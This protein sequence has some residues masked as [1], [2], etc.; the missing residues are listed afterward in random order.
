MFEAQSS[1]NNF[2]EHM[3]YEISSRSE[4]DDG[5]ALPSIKYVTDIL[6]VF[7][8]TY[9]GIS[10]SVYEG[11]SGS[12]YGVSEGVYKYVSGSVYEGVIG[13]IY[14]DMSG[15]I[16]KGVN[17]SI[18]EDINRS[19]Y[20]GVSESVEDNIFDDFENEPITK[21]VKNNISE[22]GNSEDEFKNSP[23]REIHIGQT[24][25]SF[26]VLEQC[27]KHYLT[28]MRFKTKIV[29]PMKNQEWKS[30]YIDCEFLLN[31]S[32]QKCP[33]LVFVNK[34]NEKHTHNLSKSESLQQF[35][36]SFQKILEQT[37]LA[38]GNLQPKVQEY[39]DHVLYLTKECWAYVFT[40]R[41]FS[42]NTHSTQCIENEAKYT[43]L[44][45]FWN[46]NPTASLLNVSNMI[47]KNIDD[48]YKKY[49]TQNSLVLQQKQILE[50]D[51]YEKLQILLNMA[52]E[53]CTES[54]LI[55][56]R[57]YSGEGL[58][59]FDTSQELSIQVIKDNNRPLQTETFQ[60]LEKIRGQEINNR[61]AIK[62]D[63][64]KATYSRGLELC[65]KALDMAMMS[66]SNGVLKEFMISNPIQ[67][68]DKGHP[69]S[70]RYLLAIEN[71]G[72][73]NACSNNQNETVSGS[74]KKNKHQCALCRS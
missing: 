16:Y 56:F 65:K 24:F 44:Q 20:K 61:D 60:V 8:N 66:S 41:K 9:E 1:Y 18:Y 68:K 30:A 32:Y 64:K 6:P 22:G 27:L 53:N 52:L 67:Y 63:S 3:N 48:M 42:A 49:L 23:L 50:K 72:T 46:M 70:K 36:P 11:A 74:M 7:E 12:I 37:K 25:T 43:K 33:N 39:C 17:E 5:F 29:D 10:G 58:L 31:V 26:E 21:S 13:S 45:E 51:D 59:I 71:H 19:I 47:F 28:R 57:W 14:E 55:P 4:N 35:L 2:D 15:S 38:T 69:S 40:K 73:K 34:F 62:S 54:Q